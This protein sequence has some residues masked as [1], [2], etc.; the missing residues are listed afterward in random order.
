MKWQYARNQARLRA[1]RLA[2]EAER[3][4]LKKLTLSAPAF[5]EEKAKINANKKQKNSKGKLVHP[6]KK[7]AEKA[8][9]QKLKEKD[10]REKQKPRE[11][12][13]KEKDASSA[14]IKAPL[15]SD[16]PS[17]PVSMPISTRTPPLSSSLNR[18]I[19]LVD[20]QQSDLHMDAD[21]E[22]ID[23]TNPSFLNVARPLPVPAHFIADD[24]REVK[25]ED[26][27]AETRITA[28]KTGKKKRSP[29]RQVRS[30]DL[31]LLLSPWVI[32][33]SLPC[34]PCYC[35]HHLCSF[36]TGENL[37]PFAYSTSKAT[38]EYGLSLFLVLATL[39]DLN[40]LCSC[41]VR[42]ICPSV[43]TFSFTL[44][45]YIAPFSRIQNIGPNSFRQLAQA[46]AH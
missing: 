35:I 30:V 33:K 13:K 2:R 19:P 20:A 31:F 15:L 10:D 27:E 36:F 42:R 22:I 18:P 21:T 4:R 28:H 43:C 1:K 12:E 41:A 40:L 7:A 38:G 16:A 25:E 45:Y 14:L 8:R 23:A 26:K 17:A 29:Q 34:R 9:L 32:R 11:S 3:E 6:K 46:L 37:L 39:S 44:G 5:D 24:E